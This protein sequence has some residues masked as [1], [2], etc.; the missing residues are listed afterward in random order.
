M[1]TKAAIKTVI[2]KTP[3]VAVNKPALSQNGLRQCLRVAGGGSL[4][5]IISQLMGWNYGVFFTVFPMFLLGMVPLLN[6]NIIRQF[7]ANVSLNALEVS[8]V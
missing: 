1:F 4:G 6:G 3:A 8:M 2:N 5:F 7:L